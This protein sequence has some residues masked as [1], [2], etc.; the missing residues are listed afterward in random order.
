MVCPWR[1]VGAVGGD[2]G[3]CVTV[4]YALHSIGGR[5]TETNACMRGHV[6][7]SWPLSGLAACLALS[8]PF[9][10]LSFPFLFVLSARTRLVAAARHFL[11]LLFQGHSSFGWACPSGEPEDFFSRY[12]LKGEVP[13]YSFGAS[14]VESASERLWS[15]RNFEADLK[16]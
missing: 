10:G 2:V 8:F 16:L 5:R 15:L 9:P 7:R 14:G 6:A 3:G 12:L 11:V 4:G 1:L 13:L